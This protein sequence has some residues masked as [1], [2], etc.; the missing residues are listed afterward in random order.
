M[1]IVCTQI[2]KGTEIIGI[3]LNWDKRYITLCPVAT[4]I[5]LAF[6]ML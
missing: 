1:G 5:G 3:R 6:R 2:E 4:V